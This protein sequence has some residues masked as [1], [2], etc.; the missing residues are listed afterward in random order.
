MKHYMVIVVN[1]LKF[2]Y[3]CTSDFMEI[4]VNAHGTVNNV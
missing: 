2:D 4:V 3:C 1:L